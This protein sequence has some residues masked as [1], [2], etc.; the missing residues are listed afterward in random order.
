VSLTNKFLTFL[1]AMQEPDGRLHNYMSYGRELAHDEDTGDHLGR[2]LWATG[3]VVDSSLPRAI[4]DPAKEIFDKALPWALRSSSPRVGA[5][6]IMGLA[7][8]VNHFKDDSNAKRN[9]S[10]LVKELTT[11]YEGRRS[12]DWR[13]FEDVISYENWRLPE[14]LFE[15]SLVGEDCL[16]VA[17]ESL[18]FLAEVE[19]VDGMLVPVGCN[20]WYPR[21]GTKAEFDQLP[22][23]AGSAVEALA[24]AA[25]ASRSSHYMD[26]AMAA[27]GWYH[28]ANQMKANLY[29]PS[30]GACHDGITSSGLNLNQ[31]AESTLS[32]L[33]AVTR[34]KSIV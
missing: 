27:F 3:C 24:S 4:K 29:D 10:R 5:H 16:E 18:G 13:W 8:Y 30:T 34:L 1:L 7:R 15:S 17:E 33:L 28:G 26:L 31:G 2:T 25:L 9:L 6:A 14:C 21:G 20:G 22:V 23:E 19:F 32:Y 11:L 12:G